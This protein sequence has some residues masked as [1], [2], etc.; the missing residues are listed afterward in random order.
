MVFRWKSE[1][2]SESHFRQQGPGRQPH[3]YPSENSN[4][5]RAGHMWRWTMA[6]KRRFRV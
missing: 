4:R 1:K 3:Q 6:G 2:M 5:P